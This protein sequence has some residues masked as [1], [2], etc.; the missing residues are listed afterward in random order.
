MVR[1]DDDKS[2]FEAG[3]GDMRNDVKHEE[4]H[5]DSEDE[6][7]RD[8]TVVDESEKGELGEEEALTKKKDAEDSEAT[9]QSMITFERVVALILIAFVLTVVGYGGWLFLGWKEA[10]ERMLE[11]KLVEAT[12]Q[13]EYNGKPVTIGYVQTTP[14]SGR[15]YGAL[16]VLDE[17]GRFTLATNGR[18]GAS[19]GKHKVA[20]MSMTT[21]FPPKPL[22]PPNYTDLSQTP[23]TIEVKSTA[24]KN[25]F[26]LLLKGELPVDRRQ[27]DDSE[28]PPGE[29]EPQPPDQPQPPAPSNGQQ[30]A[31][32]D[33]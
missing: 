9:P 20:V 27:D 4:A 28:R 11:P 19:V 8:S 16:G 10:F 32:P 24:E 7:R 15:G 18:P 13:V 17:Q 29:P 12:G 5:G 26:T 23:L 30:E 2:G 14:M 22:V 33:G 25:Q 3:N 31:L 1:S 21:D 6:A